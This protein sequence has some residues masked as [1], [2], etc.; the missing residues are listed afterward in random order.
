MTLIQWWLPN[1]QTFNAANFDMIIINIQCSML[2]LNLK[3]NYAV[4][5]KF[6]NDIYSWLYTRSL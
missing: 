6:L 5:L 4:H 2:K 1:K 3:Q